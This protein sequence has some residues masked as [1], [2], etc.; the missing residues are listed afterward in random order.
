M[1]SV[2]LRGE[3]ISVWTVRRPPPTP[4]ALVVLVTVYC[5][6]TDKTVILSLSGKGMDRT[7]KTYPYRSHNSSQSH[8]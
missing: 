6:D 8:A 1:N 5:P 7:Y 3:N 4:M 2:T